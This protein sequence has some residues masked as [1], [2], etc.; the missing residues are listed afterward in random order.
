MMQPTKRLSEPK[1][2]LII[3]VIYSLLITIAFLGP[4]P[5][6]SNENITYL[7]K[8]VHIGLYL[9]LALIWLYYIFLRD[10]Y[11]I[12][13]NIV[14]VVLI[15]CFSYGIVIEVSQ[16]MFTLSRRFDLFDIIANGIGCLLG[17]LLFWR[18][19]NKN[20]H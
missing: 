3:G 14:F 1:T 16:Q 20:I 4:S 12:S 5:A 17:S 6:L 8:L 10:Q 13:K 19:K 2:L 7:D 9:I 11:H 18:L 15:L